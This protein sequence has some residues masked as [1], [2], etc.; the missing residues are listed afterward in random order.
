MRLRHHGDGQLGQERDHLGRRDR[1]VLDPVTAAR[2]GIA[3]RGRGEDGLRARDA[4][5][6]EAALRRVRVADPIAERGEVGEPR[7]VEQ[8]LDRPAR[9]AR[10]RGLGQP[11]RPHREH[12]LR[13]RAALGRGAQPVERRAVVVGA[14]I[15][16][17][18]DAERREPRADRGEVGRL[19]A[20]ARAQ[21]RIGAEQAPVGARAADR[22]EPRRVEDPER[23]AAVLDAER[24]L[25]HPGVEL[26]AIELA[27]DGLVI[28]DA[29][30][31]SSPSGG[32]GASARASC[33]RVLTAGGPHAIEHSAAASACRCTWWSHRPGSSAPPRASITGSP[34]ERASPAPISA[35]R[36]PAIRTSSGA[37]PPT[38]APRISNGAALAARRCRH[39]GRARVRA[40]RARAAATPPRLRR[41][42]ERARPRRCPGSRSPVSPRTRARAP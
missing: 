39:R 42:H 10:R 9:H 37:R 31:P 36:S 41:A 28:G 21:L 29:A 16:E 30:Q 3:Q 1:R 11:G 18:R 20:Q 33:S 24:A 32:G 2:T 12:A 17:L 38:S 19:V 6:G 34:G 25:A 23:A 27:R 15:G 40:A 5:H 8:R 7:L 4:V 22:G 26:T 14:G 35:M 13:Q